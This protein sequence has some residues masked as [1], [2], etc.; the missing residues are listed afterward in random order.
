M[1]IGQE[2]LTRMAR[3][4]RE[5]EQEN[6]ARDAA[7]RQPM[8]DAI[9]KGATMTVWYTI[10]TLDGRT[11][12]RTHSLDHKWEW[13]SDVVAADAECW[14][15]DVS[16]KETDDGDIITVHGKPYARVLTSLHA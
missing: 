2:H 5:A 6:A 3:L 7:K 15:A 14:T 9:L 12:S 8:V 10:K 4:Y 16:L 1:G 11:L 13:I